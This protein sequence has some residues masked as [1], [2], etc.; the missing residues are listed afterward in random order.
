MKNLPES[1]RVKRSG[2]ECIASDFKISRE[3]ESLGAVPALLFTQPNSKHRRLLSPPP[4]ALLCHHSHPLGATGISSRCVLPPALHGA[5][6]GELSRQQVRLSSSQQVRLSSSNVPSFQ[7]TASDG[8]A[9]APPCTSS[10][11]RCCGGNPHG[12]LFKAFM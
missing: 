2:S 4:Q 8:R 3:I 9:A 1:E 6:P 10:L 11:R 12:F 7:G 5:N